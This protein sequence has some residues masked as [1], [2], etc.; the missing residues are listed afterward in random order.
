MSN[1]QSIGSKGGK[2]SGFTCIK[3]RVGRSVIS[4]VIGSTTMTI[5]TSSAN[6]LRCISSDRSPKCSTTPSCSSEGIGFAISG[7]RSGSTRSNSSLRVVKP[8]I[9]LMSLRIHDA[10]L[11]VTH[12]DLSPDSI[13]SWAS[14][15]SRHLSFVYSTGE[16]AFEV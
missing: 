16:S 13:R 11:G 3:N 6:L 5:M 9:R 10:S 2:S 14:L 12:G 15:I 7:G 4:K 8:P 1:P